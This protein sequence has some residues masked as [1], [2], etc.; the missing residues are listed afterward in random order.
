MPTWSRVPRDRLLTTAGMPC[1]HLRMRSTP[2]VAQMH[3][4]AYHSVRSRVGDG[5][6]IT[7]DRRRPGDGTITSGT[8][9]ARRMSTSIVAC[10]AGAA[11]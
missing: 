2:S 8:G 10:S 9:A 1:R 4:F 11:A 5:Q 6:V 3:Q 7:P